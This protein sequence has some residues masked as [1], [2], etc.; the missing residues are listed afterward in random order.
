[1][2]SVD[3]FLGGGDGQAVDSAGE[4]VGGD[5]VDDAEVDDFCLVALI[6]GDL[7]ERDA[8]DLGGD[9]AVNVFIGLEGADEGWLV[10]EV[11]EIRA[12]RSG[13]NRR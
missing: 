4:A 12:A 11:G 13:C 10:G 8:E 6:A 2:V 1:M 3:E 9:G 7:I 5:A